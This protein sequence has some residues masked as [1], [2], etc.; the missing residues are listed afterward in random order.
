MNLSQAVQI[1][2]PTLKADAK[3]ISLAVR[4]VFVKKTGKGRGYQTIGENIKETAIAQAEKTLGESLSR[5]EL[6]E[7]DQFVAERLKFI[8]NTFTE[9]NAPNRG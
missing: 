3:E 4:K 1:Y 5:K 7:I 8:K 2:V 9:L 6:R